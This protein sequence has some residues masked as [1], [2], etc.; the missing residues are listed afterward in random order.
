[1]KIAYL[2]TVYS[3]DN[4]K[5]FKSAIESLINQIIPEGNELRIYLGVDGN[6]GS[7]LSNTIDFYRNYIF[8]IVKSNQNLGLAGILNL[9][10]DNLENEDFLFRM[11][12]D[13][14]CLP[15]RTIVQLDFLHK[16]PDC[17]A[18]GSAM[19]EINES[20]KIIGLKKA[21]LSNQINKIAFYRNPFNHPTM[22]LRRDFFNLVGKYD[23][24]LRKSQDYELWLRALRMGYRMENVKE[25]LLLFRV[26]KDFQKK[27]NSFQNFKNEFIISFNFIIHSKKYI[28]IFFILIKLIIRLL[29]SKFSKIIYKAIRN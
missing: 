28:Y 4:L 5:Y 8:K 13:D 17:I 6:I 12:S 25:P 27:R 26:D 1:M 2:I 14:I 21:F 23:S 15:N 19:R 24:K 22:A 7:D 29:P 3:G 9:I 18:V 11:D 16:N 20:N 10:I